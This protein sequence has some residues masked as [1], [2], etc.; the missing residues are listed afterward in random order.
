MIR[1]EDIAIAKRSIADRF[2]HHCKFG[3]Q[4]KA[5]PRDVKACGQ[6]LD[7]EGSRQ[8]GM[9][10]T[11]AAIRVLGADGSGDARALLPQLIQYV[12]R[13]DEIE[14]AT[15]T[16]DEDKAQL[17]NQ[18]SR[19]DANVIKVSELLLALAFVERAVCPTEALCKK[20]A[21]RL[22][23]G[24]IDDRGWGYFLD[25]REGEPQLLP[26]AH[27]VRALSMHGYSVG[28]PLE[29]ILNAL[30]TPSA[31]SAAVTRVDISVRVFCLYVLSFS[32]NGQRTIPEE[33]LRRIFLSM[34][35]RLE[36]LLDFDDIEQ[37]VEYSRNG[38]HY[39]VRVPW[40]LYLIPLACT[41]ATR[42]TF[43]SRAAQVRL[44]SVLRAVATKEGF[45]YPHSGEHVSSRT[46]A[47]V[48]DALTAIED[49]LPHTS[50]WGLFPSYLMDRFRRALNSAYLT[51]AGYLFAAALIVVSIL[52]WYRDGGSIK[53]L[54]P[55]LLSG[56]TL[57][58]LTVRK[59]R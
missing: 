14:L 9:H 55:G 10:G 59:A 32:K 57:L 24:R 46:N 17:A 29:Y 37:N 53:D 26:T 51:W 52:R 49:C 39:Y 16:R 47:I 28:K 31:G 19:D 4:V 44:G 13:R 58:L 42:R 22:M 27:A 40:Q 50:S 45:L 8:R 41:L 23:N 3:P 43:A 35:E 56:I 20:L 6:F 1:R 21:E 11:A 30:T 12:E 38:E 48:Y 7:E 34:W 36:P 5:L 18:I 2:L 15:V 25:R 54:A 33:R